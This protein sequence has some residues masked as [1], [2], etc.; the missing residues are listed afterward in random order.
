MGQDTILLA[1]RKRMKNRNYKDIH[2]YKI[3]E[4]DD[5]GNIK[6]VLYSVSA[7][8]PLSEKR[9]ERVAHIYVFACLLR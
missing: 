8:E 7:I 6:D 1:L 3:N 5:K 9:V 4:I 2:I